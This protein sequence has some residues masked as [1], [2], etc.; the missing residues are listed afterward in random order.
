VSGSEYDDVISIIAV[1]ES[2]FHR[3][4]VGSVY[5]VVVV[6]NSAIVHNSVVV[7]SIS[8]VVKSADDVVVV[9]V[10]SVVVVAPKGSR[11]GK[12]GGL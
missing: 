9:V 3:A 10:V 7:V 11:F 6:V 12:F 5:A 8:V 1:V 4:I 2:K